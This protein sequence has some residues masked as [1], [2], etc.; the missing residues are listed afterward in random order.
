M[1]KK[2][3]IVEIENPFEAFQFLDDSSKLK[4]KESKKSE[5]KDEPVVTTDITPEAEAALEKAAKEAQEA[6]KKKEAKKTTEVV[7]PVI[8]EVEPE[9]VETEEV[10]EETEGNEFLGFAKFLSEEGVIDLEDTDEIKSEKDLIKVVDRTV[11]TKFENWKN[12]FPEDAQKFLQFVVDGGKPSDFHKYYYSEASFEEFTVDTEEDQKYVITESLKLEGY[13]EE[14][15]QDELTDAVD[16][17]KL[18]KKAQVH[19]KKL[20]KY[21]KE[22][23]KALLEAQKAYAEAEEARR[24]EEWKKFEE[25][26]YSKD[27]IAG[28]K[29]TKKMKDD[30]WEYMTKPVNKKTGQTQ[31]QIDSEQNEDSRYLYAYLMKNKFN[32]EA[33]EEQVQTKQVSKLKAKLS[34]YSDT[35]IKIKSGTTAKADTN[36]GNPFE[37]WKKVLNS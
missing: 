1:S 7:E 29:F 26:L 4:T 37:A 10:V 23:K 22:Q 33:L 35:R 11:N 17:G 24:K 31:Y 8:E 30:T 6:L 32:K 21:E 2:E 28:F 13:T 14:E 18:D 19:L 25:G 9:V 3:E 15:I 34:N 16:L 27:T 20:Q 36:E 12:S 5:S